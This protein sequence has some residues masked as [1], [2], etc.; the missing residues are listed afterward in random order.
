[1]T[2]EDCMSKKQIHI[3]VLSVLAMLAFALADITSDI[4]YTTQINS[5]S[6][7]FYGGI[8]IATQWGIPLLIS[9]WGI[10]FLDK[11]M[12]YSTH[13]IYCKFLPQVIITGVCWWIVSALI[14][15]QTNFANEMDIDT[16]FECMGI[17]LSEPYNVFLLQLFISLFA[18]YPLLARISKSKE[19]LQYALIT[20]FVICMFL[21]ILQNIPYIRLV[22]L[23][24]NQI[25]WN[26]FTSFGF[27]V[28]FGIWIM[29][30]RFAWHHRIVIYCMGVLATVAMFS[31]TKIFSATSM[32]IDT[33]FV[34]IN[35]PFVVMQVL[36][37]F[38]FVKEVF[39][40]DV[41]NDST[42]NILS[43]FTRNIYGYIVLYVIVSNL[44]S[45]YIPISFIFLFPVIC[46]VLINVICSALRRL[47][48]M[49]FLLCD[50]KI[51]G[52][53]I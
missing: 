26:F 51:R 14:H 33:R 24:T 19:L 25:N 15:L 49:S 3:S 41:K 47:P 18:F 43:E 31:L 16:F 27:Y 12:L 46:F 29:K 1:M 38:V 50:F 5:F 30:N 28:F 42:K 39:S 44:I 36:A 48:I 2:G 35:S 6:W 21:P 20:S 52:E 17:V 45:F 7:D 11:D 53:R 34:N 10:I 13:T 23:F 37:I 4:W 8:T 40:I 22:N 32:G 9:L